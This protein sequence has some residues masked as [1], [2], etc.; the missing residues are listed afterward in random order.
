LVVSKAKDRA[1]SGPRL[2]PECGRPRVQHP[3]RAVDVAG[4]GP[5]DAGY[6]ARPNRFRQDDT[7]TGAAQ[8]WGSTDHVSSPTY[9]IVNDYQRADG[10][11]LYHADAYRL[12]A[13][14]P[15]DTAILD[16]DRILVEGILVV[17]WADRIRSALPADSL[18]VSMSWINPEQRHLVFT[19][20]G[21]DYET[22][23]RKLEEALYGA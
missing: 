14:N 15:L 10:H 19:P 9:V 22:L 6:R 20:H 5:G 21:K 1:P 17:E 4:Q 18:W 11:H 16:L 8:G 13:E 7:G 2:G 12:D 3:R 23:T